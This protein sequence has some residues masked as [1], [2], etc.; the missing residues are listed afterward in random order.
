MASR[1]I[2]PKGG[3]DLTTGR[4]VN[5][6][7][8]EG[9]AVS[10]G[11]VICEVETE[12]AVFEVSAP[13]NGFLL[14][15]SAQE[16]EEVGIL[17]TIGYVGEKD[18][19]IAHEK[20]DV[21]NQNHRDTGI[22]LAKT[23]MHTISETISDGEKIKIAPKARKLARDQG[24]S[25]NTLHSAR[26]DGKITTED[27]QRVIQAQ[28][29]VE[30]GKDVPE[31]AQVL[32]PKPIQ[33]AAA[34]RLS[35]SWSTTPHIFMTVSVDMTACSAFRVQHPELDVTFTDLVIRA[36]T[37]A[38]AKF[39]DINAS[40]V[41][42]DTLYMWQDIDIG[43]AVNTPDGLVVPVIEDAD[44]L[45]LQDLAVETKRLVKKMRE[46]WQEAA[47]P[48]RFT[49]SNLGMHGV[50]HFTAVINPPEAAILAISSIR[51]TPVVM[52][53]GDI[54]A[55]EMMNM[56]LSLDHRVGGG[57][58]AA[59]FLNEVKLHLENPETMQSD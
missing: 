14:R 10:K 40:Y 7:K 58:L 30:A 15:I 4:I 33:R 36:C 48:S 43:L 23:E 42:E 49:I 50:D 8:K 32:S 37:L 28:K 27:V 44:L 5:W 22:K 45:P 19:E 26:A 41:D 9:E 12:K 51:R 25:L 18:E 16:G 47:K 57:V 2:M 53:N 20:L 39:P 52:E 38:L 31:N 21:E 11:E 35:A 1:V 54:A 55:C 29:N 34:R 56:T 6:L 59:E 13:Q 17:S 24:I 46:G 3:Q